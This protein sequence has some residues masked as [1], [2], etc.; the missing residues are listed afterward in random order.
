MLN[1]P[2]WWRNWRQ[3][4]PWRYGYNKDRSGWDASVSDTDL[5]RHMIE[6]DQRRTGLPKKGVLP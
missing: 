6:Q 2:R 5:L 3:R 4:N 1:A